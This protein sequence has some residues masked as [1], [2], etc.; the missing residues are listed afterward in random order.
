MQHFYIQT[1]KLVQLIW[2]Y[3]AV[4]HDLGIVSSDFEIPHIDFLLDVADAKMIC[5]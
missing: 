1:F 4:V 2:V 5:M 3:S